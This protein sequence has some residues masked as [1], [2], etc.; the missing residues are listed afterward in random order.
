MR[1]T[2]SLRA[3]VLAAAAAG[4]LLTSACGADNAAAPTSAPSAPASSPVDL[5]GDVTALPDPATP[6]TTAPATTAPTRTSAAS[7]TATTASA[8][9]RGGVFSGTRQVFLLP[10]NSEAT[11][12]VVTGNKLGLSSSFGDKDLFVIVPSGDRFSIKT[13]KLR[14]GGEPLCVSAKVGPGG[15]PALIHLVGCDAAAPSQKFRFR[16]TGESNGKPTYTIYTG[17]D[18]FIVQDPTGEIAGLGTGVIAATIGE[19][20]ADIDTPFVLADKGKA[21]L[22][23]LD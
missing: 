16:E 14:V 18:T 21:S 15:A 12:G 3:G 2:D 22:P 20:T 13:A 5:A 10:K 9:P 11:V 7:R 1:G 23:A 8:S 6:A 4:L 17:A 19:G